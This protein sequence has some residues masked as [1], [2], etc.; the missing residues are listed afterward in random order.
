MMYQA[1]STSNQAELVELFSSVFNA[2]EGEQEGAML[3][4]LTSQLA[5]LIDH[6]A[7]MAFGAYE[8]GTLIGAIFFSRLQFESPVSVYMLSPVAVAT[9]QQGQG[10]GQALIQHGLEILKE[11]AVE[12][13]ITYGDPAFYSK[14]GFAPLSEELIQAPVKL[15]MPF[16][17]LG[18]SLSEKPLPKLSGRPLCVEPFNDPNLW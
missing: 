11:R 17:W 6:D 13:A 5:A 12:V 3:R 8:E 2:S 10:V 15:S 18:Q 7:V 4:Q 16:G 14:V 1:L 9:E